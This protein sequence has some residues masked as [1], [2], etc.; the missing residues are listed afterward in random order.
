MR[1]GKTGARG[2]LY[3]SLAVVAEPACLQKPGT[4][5]F[6]H[7]GFELFQG[8]DFAIGRNADTQFRRELL[9]HEP[10]LAHFNR[11]GGRKYGRVIGDRGQCRCGNVF[12]LECGYVDGFGEPP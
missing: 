1:L 5:E 11:I 7:G 9:L 3:L 10:V 4:A 2:D 12:K 6:V 8:I